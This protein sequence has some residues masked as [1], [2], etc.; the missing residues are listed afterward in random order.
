ME[1]GEVES[2]EKGL[3]TIKELDELISYFSLRVGV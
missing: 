3:E 2:Y 1:R